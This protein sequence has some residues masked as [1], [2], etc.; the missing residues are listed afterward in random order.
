VR[1]RIGK[2]LWRNLISKKERKIRHK[3]RLRSREPQEVR[4]FKCGRSG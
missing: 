3:D 2:G 4:T 1:E